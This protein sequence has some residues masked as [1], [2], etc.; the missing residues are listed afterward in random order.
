M[1]I[2]YNTLSDLHSLWIY[3]FFIFKEDRERERGGNISLL[4]TPISIKLVSILLQRNGQKINNYN[5]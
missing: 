1:I 4:P 5:F 2:K 3:F